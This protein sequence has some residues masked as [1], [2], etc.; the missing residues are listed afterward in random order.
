MSNQ[1]RNIQI[2]LGA[3]GIAGLVALGFQLKDRFQELAQVSADY[4]AAVNGIHDA[5]QGLR[6]ESQ[7]LRDDLTQISGHS[8]TE[9]I[10]TPIP[11]YLDLCNNYRNLGKPCAEITLSDGTIINVEAGSTSQNII[12]IID[13][14]RSGEI[15]SLIEDALPIEESDPLL[16]YEFTG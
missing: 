5:N 9:A 8:D 11:E 12:Q 15:E 1:I 2:T 13:G 4:N 10:I 14:L 16:L 3:A 7:G 6:Q